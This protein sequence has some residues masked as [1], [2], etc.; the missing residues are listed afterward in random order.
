MKESNSYIEVSISAEEIEAKL[1][2]KQYDKIDKKELKQDTKKEKVEHEKDAIKDD[3]S[4]VKK[5]DKG[6]PSEKKDAEKKALKKDMKFDKDSKKKMEG[7]KAKDGEYTGKAPAKVKPKK[8][9][10]QMLTDIA[11]ERFGKKKEVS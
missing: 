6:A 4:K 2:K 8:S 9:Y 10:A 1:D 5:L 11:A 3:K 7:Q